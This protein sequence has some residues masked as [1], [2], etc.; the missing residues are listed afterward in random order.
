MWKSVR[1]FPTEAFKDNTTQ[2][3]ACREGANDTGQGQQ[4][5]LGNESEEPAIYDPAIKA[6]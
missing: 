1:N 5:V 2:K 3:Q 6:W 4:V